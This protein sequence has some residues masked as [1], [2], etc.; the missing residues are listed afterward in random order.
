MGIVL[1]Y[2]LIPL[3]GIVM[4]WYSS[5]KVD[6]AEEELSLAQERIG[7]LESENSKLSA[8]VI[9]NNAHKR[10]LSLAQQELTRLRN[11]INNDCSAD[12]VIG[13]PELIAEANKRIRQSNTEV[14][15]KLST[16]TKGDK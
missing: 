8:L 10:S 7:I 14:S 6:K 5:Y 3:I 4:L 11:E 12:D 16:R 9:T 1:R 15:G 13:L 2:I